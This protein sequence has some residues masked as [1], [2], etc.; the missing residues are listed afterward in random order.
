MKYKIKINLLHGI[1]NLVESIC[2]NLMTC[3]DEYIL[4]GAVQILKIMNQYLKANVMRSQ[5]TIYL[6]TIIRNACEI[7]RCLY[8]LSEFEKQTNPIQYYLILIASGR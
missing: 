7:N 6:A 5:L 4:S 8:L 2:F 3:H 1:T